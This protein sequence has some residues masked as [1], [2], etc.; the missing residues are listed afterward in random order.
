[1]TL[2]FLSV[3]WWGGVFQES[4]QMSNVTTVCLLQ[5]TIKN[6]GY[7]NRYHLYNTRWKLGIQHPIFLIKIYKSL[8]KLCIVSVIIPI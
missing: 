4:D 3:K 8:Q 5:S 1:M 7:N 2:H 6:N